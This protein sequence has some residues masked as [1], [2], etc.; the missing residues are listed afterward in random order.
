MTV[1]ENEKDKGVAARSRLFVFDGYLYLHKPHVAIMSMNPDDV[2]AFGETSLGDILEEAHDRSKE[3]KELVERLID[4]LSDLMES[5]DDAVAL[6]PLI[7]EYLE[8]NVQ[9]NE[10]LVKIAQVIQRMYNASIKQSG[11]DG[12][13]G[14]A[15]FTDQDKEE[16]RNIAENMSEADAEELIEEAESAVEEVDKELDV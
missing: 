3:Q 1:G 15:G 16:L 8:I 12:D 10:Q 7:K 9:N 2:S 5:E 14:G 13:G 4:Q 6:V 11:S